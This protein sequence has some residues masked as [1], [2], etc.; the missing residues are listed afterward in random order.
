MPVPFI[1][2]HCH[3]VYA[4]LPELFIYLLHPFAEATHRIIR[5]RNNQD[6]KVLFDVCR[7]LLLC[8]NFHPLKHLVVCTDGKYEATERITGILGTFLLV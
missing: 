1:E 2:L 3:I 8:Q 4:C 5:S 6:R 7:A